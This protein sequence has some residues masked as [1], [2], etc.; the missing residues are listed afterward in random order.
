MG[1]RT[2]LW[3]NMSMLVTMRIMEFHGCLW[4]FVRICG[5]SWEYMEVYGSLDEYE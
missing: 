4:E 5:G 2:N 3:N 1:V